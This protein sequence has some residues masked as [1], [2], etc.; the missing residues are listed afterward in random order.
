MEYDYTNVVLFLL[1]SIGTS[2]AEI[3]VA[4]A[5]RKYLDVNILLTLDKHSIYIDGCRMRSFIYHLNSMFSCL[6]PSGFGAQD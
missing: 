3:T 2:I 1:L 4:K 6:T 5:P